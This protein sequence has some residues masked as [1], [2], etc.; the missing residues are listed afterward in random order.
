MGALVHMRLTVLR[1]ECTL[2]ETILCSARPRWPQW[3]LGHAGRGQDRETK[4]TGLPRTATLFLTYFCSFSS[5][6]VYPKAKCTP[7][8]SA[9][10]G[11]LLL[12]SL[13]AACRSLCLPPTP[14]AHLAVPL[15][16]SQ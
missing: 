14:R 9:T 10:R 4:P 1:V 5:P 15:H 13:P 8:S 11:I 12:N 16:F 7:R 2:S 3:A 6:P